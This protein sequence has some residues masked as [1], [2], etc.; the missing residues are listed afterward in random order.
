MAKTTRENASTATDWDRLEAALTASTDRGRRGPVVPRDLEGFD[1]AELAVLRRLATRA[2]LSRSRAGGA[3]RG[4]VVFLHGITG[5]DLE[6][7]SGS[8]RDKIWINLARL[9]A[10]RIERLKLSPD[11]AAEAD[12]TYRVVATRPNKRYYA[13]GILSLRARWNAEPF[14]Y[15]WRKDIDTASDEL[16]RFISARFPGQPVHIVAHSMGGLVARNMIR[17]HPQLWESMQDPEGSAG[18]RLIMLGT[19]NYGSFAIV[20]AM[21]GEDQ[22]MRLLEKCDVRHDMPGLLGITNTFLGSYQLLPAPSKLPATLEAL[23]QADTWPRDAH[24]SQAH[25][26]R[27]FAFHAALDSVSTVSATRMIYV[28]GCGR[29]TITG[30]TIAGPGDFEYVLSHDGDGRVP[31]ALGL[32]PGVPTYY[33]DEV[34]GDLARNEDVLRALDDLLEAG[35]TSVLGTNVLRGAA[36][37]TPSMRDYHTSTDRALMNE[38]ERIARLAHERGDRAQLSLADLSLGEDALIRASLGSGEGSRPAVPAKPRTGAATAARQVRLRVVP[39]LADV[40]DVKAPAV[41]VGHYRGMAP[42]NAIGAI[43]R[44]LNGWISLAV[45]RGMIG[46]SLGETFFVPSNGAIAAGAVVVAGMGAPGTFTE[47]RLRTLVTNVTMGAGALGFRSFATLLIGA[48]EGNL[49]PDKVLR[50]LL[51]GIAEGLMSLPDETGQP[52]SLQEVLI[53]EHNPERFLKLV[54]D[55]KVLQKDERLRVELEVKEPGSSV[56]RRAQ[57]LRATRPGAPARAAQAPAAGSAP[58]DEVRLTLESPDGGKGKF[59]FSAIMR[60]A[61]V[62]VRDVDVSPTVFAGLA[63]ALQKSESGKE[64]EQYGRLLFDYLIPEDFDEVIGGAGSVRLIVDRATASFPWEMACFRPRSDSGGARWLG[65]DRALTRQFRTM[66]SQPPGTTP[67]LNEQVR[68]LVI[69]DPAPEPELQLPYARREGRQV[70]ET[71][72]RLDSSQ[73]RIDVESRIGSSECDIVEILALILTGGFDIVHYAGHGDYDPADPTTAGWIFGRDRIMTARD[74]F[75]ARRV[76]RLVFA[77]ACFSGAIH[78]GAAH[79]AQELSYGLA[80]IAQ[81][82]FERGVPNYLGSGWPVNDAQAAT[83]AAEFYKG[84]LGARTLRE[85]V[86]AAR[87]KIYGEAGGSTW[88]AYQLYGN[89]D[90]VVVRLAR[91]NASTTPGRGS[92][93]VRSGRRVSHGPR[94]RS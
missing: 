92:R 56:L 53:V 63:A 43:D 12:T 45:K 79:D 81:A 54:D 3:A 66:L 8:D 40:C 58:S 78:G 23:Y 47:D 73:L 67:P 39:T 50:A 26:N 2:R 59:R 61:V 86:S 38:L 32:L 24:I 4:N 89:P 74:I 91:Q 36:R 21:T 77:N 62:P 72:R 52:S 55:L 1:E 88:G 22:M 84:V 34:H 49:A 17:R 69:A 83:F 44:R 46:G 57:R 16:A 37:G 20:Q 25:L 27:A 65:L 13:R 70:V 29:P 14:A 75:R 42:I 82:F 68:V 80:T 87:G 5:A 71:L 15:D 93:A 41:I 31:H 19:P 28:A 48:G 85:A 10:G 9:I 7:V 90:D 11:T 64:Q 51:S 33:A 60:N 6:T 18:G 35:T 76:P 94:R 30:M